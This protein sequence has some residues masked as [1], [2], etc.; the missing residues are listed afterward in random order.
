MN[1]FHVF[2]SFP[3]ALAAGIIIAVACS[4]L[5]V[6]VVLKRLVFIGA[7][8]SEVATCGLAAS[9]YTHMNPFLG[10]VIFTLV[11]VTLLA[12]S[13]EEYRVPRDA[14][15]AM[16]F[17]LSSGLAILFVS[18]SS[19]GLEEVKSFL[20]GDLILTSNADL[21]VL[22]ISVVPITILALIFLRPITYTFV[23]RDEARVLGIRV[24]FWELFFYYVM[25]I[26]ISAASKLGGMLLV[27]CYLV[28]PPMAGLLTNNRLVG[29]I[30]TSV[31]VAIL[32]TLTGFYFS[33]TKD[34]P[35]NQVIVVISCLF[36]VGM[37]GGKY[38]LF[39]FLKRKQSASMRS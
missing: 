21:K 37:A 34:L 27:F 36:L 11:A 22:F 6:F 15:M 35:T 16:L 5:G 17:I 23:D 14:I 13:Q 4:F 29:T 18:R 20:Y 8:L 7:T 39:G 33:Y 2:Y 1:V 25:G 26:V 24:R 32:S 31:A 28:V 12:S 10:A 3:E 9:L 19:F 38:F 30:L